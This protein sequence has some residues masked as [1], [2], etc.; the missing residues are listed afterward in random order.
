[1][2]ILQPCCLT[3]RDQCY[4]ETHL[5]FDQ[6]PRIEFSFA[7]FCWALLDWKGCILFFHCDWG[8][9]NLYRNGAVGAFSMF[10]SFLEGIS[11]SFI[12]KSRRMWIEHLQTTEVGGEACSREQD[13]CFEKAVKSLFITVSDSWTISIK[14]PV[15]YFESPHT[16]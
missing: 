8:K 13:C 1:M 6:V 9:L 15:Q 10:F 12:Q 7:I 3:W 14:T 2:F 5:C 16:K 4:R 11:L